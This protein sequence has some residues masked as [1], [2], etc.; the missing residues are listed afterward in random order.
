MKVEISLG[1]LVDKIT[2]L[3]IKLVEIKN[4]DK[5]INIQFEYDYLMQFYPENDS[6]KN[7][8]D[9]LFDVNYQ[10]WKVEDKLRLLEEENKFDQEFIELARSVYILNDERARIKKNI[11]MN[12]GSKFIEEK[13][14]KNM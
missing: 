6:I 5:L 9:Q 2:I 11:N 8:F 12:D 1:E 13:S 10:L 3:K 4:E 7:Y 14:Y